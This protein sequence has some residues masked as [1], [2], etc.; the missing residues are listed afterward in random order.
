MM[1]C[2]GRRRDRDQREAFAEVVAET[3][4]ALPGSGEPM[5]IRS[6]IRDREFVDEGGTRWQL[7]GG[8]L[9]WNRVE[10]LIRDPQVPVL[11]VYLDEVS[12]VPGAERENVLARIRP[13]LKSAGDGST[14]S[15]HTDFVAAEFKDAGH[16]SM[17][18]IEE[19]C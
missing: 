2:M 12:E 8:E 16:R 14:R 13:Y 5:E 6:P 18:V 7:R 4:G 9:R 17:L 15:D 19:S 1:G 10:R 11:H 3:V